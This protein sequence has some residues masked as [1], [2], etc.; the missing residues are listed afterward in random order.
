M[1]NIEGRAKMQGEKAAQLDVGTQFAIV[2]CMPNIVNGAFWG[3]C[4]AAE[5]MKYK[6]G[7]KSNS[8]VSVKK[9]S[10]GC[11]VEVNPEY[12]IQQ[13]VKID[14]TLVDQKDMQNIKEGIAKA[15]SQLDKYLARKAKDSTFKQTLLGIYCINDTPTIS[16]KG[17]RYPAFR[18]ELSTALKLLGK[19]G[20]K[21]KVGGSYVPAGS[22]SSVKELCSSMQVSPT[23]TGV[24][25]NVSK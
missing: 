14:P 10:G 9:I 12:L 2:Q 22:I 7:L 4:D 11:L 23:N 20:Y 17:E 19:Y 24:F 6:D 15:V 3:F 16:Y 13:M 1:S 5:A 18:V 25:I 8:N 21:V